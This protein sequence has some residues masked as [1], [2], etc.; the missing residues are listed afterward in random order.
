MH[1][2]VGVSGSIKVLPTVT[3]QFLKSLLET[4]PPPPAPQGLHRLCRHHGVVVVW[5]MTPHIAALS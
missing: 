2:I 1:T 4:P 3:V 5:I